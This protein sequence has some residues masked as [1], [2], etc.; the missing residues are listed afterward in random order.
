MVL[1][2]GYLN[3]RGPFLILRLSHVRFLTREDPVKW[4][5]VECS[6]CPAGGSNNV[7]GSAPHPRRTMLPACYSGV[8]LGRSQV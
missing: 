1:S 7:V 3:L 4:C 2:I 8:V 5:L 6:F